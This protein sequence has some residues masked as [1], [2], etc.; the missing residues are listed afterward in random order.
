MHRVCVRG[1][2]A[3]GTVLRR[4]G[5]CG[6]REGRGRKYRTILIAVISYN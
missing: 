5:R 1:R 6:R 4:V 3:T 2:W